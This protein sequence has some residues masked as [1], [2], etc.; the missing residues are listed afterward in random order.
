M[1]HPPSGLRIHPVAVLHAADAAADLHVFICVVIDR[2]PAALEAHLTSLALEQYTPLRVLQN[3]PIVLY[4]RLP[5]PR[6][7]HLQ[8][9]HTDILGELECLQQRLFS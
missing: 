4:P 1:A 8:R 2:E 7:R 6:Q 3:A 5:V 9:P